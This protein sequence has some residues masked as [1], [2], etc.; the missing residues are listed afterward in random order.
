MEAITNVLTSLEVA[1]LFFEED[2]LFLRLTILPRRAENKLLVATISLDSFAIDSEN[3]V[4]TDAKQEMVDI[5]CDVQESGVIPKKQ[6][7]K[8]LIPPSN[9]MVQLVEDMIISKPIHWINTLVPGFE[10]QT[11]VECSYCGWGQ[12]WLVKQNINKASVDS[13]C[14]DCHEL[15]KLALLEGVPK[16]LRRRSTNAKF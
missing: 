10:C 12:I 2:E 1:E 15:Y 14:T 6:E 11:E 16:V 4:Y 3:R 8:P 9:G 13:L 5:A 7:Y